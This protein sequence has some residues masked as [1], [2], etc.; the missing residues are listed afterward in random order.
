MQLPNHV[1]LYQAIE[2]SSDGSQTMPAA[3]LLTD[4]EGAAFARRLGVTLD[5]TR[6]VVRIPVTGSVASLQV[7]FSPP[8][9]VAVVAQEGEAVAPNV[10]A[11]IYNVTVRAGGRLCAPAGHPGF[12]GP[13]GSVKIGALTGF[14]TVAPTMV[15][16]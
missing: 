7:T 1:S 11:G 3:T 8:I 15:C 9:D 4:E 10:I 6:S 12:V 2:T 16:P 13:D 5:P 14:F